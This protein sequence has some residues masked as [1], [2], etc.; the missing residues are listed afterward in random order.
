[1]L[2]RAKRDGDAVRDDLRG[3]LAEHLHDQQAVLVVDEAAR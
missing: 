3:Y 2:N 1:M